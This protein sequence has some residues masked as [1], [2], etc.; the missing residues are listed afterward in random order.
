MAQMSQ[1]LSA[2][3]EL[4]DRKPASART[5]EFKSRLQRFYSSKRKLNYGRKIEPESFRNSPYD[6][7]VHP[8]FEWIRL[9]WNVRNAFDNGH[10]VSGL[11][12]ELDHD[13]LRA[14]RNPRACIR[15]RLP[16][17]L[18]IQLGW[19]KVQVRV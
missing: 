18:A 14:Y 17:C 12:G 9:A 16:V 2:S 10:D 4:P 6:S 1:K 5:C 15:L 19:Q 11:L 7:H 8:R 13:A 3:L